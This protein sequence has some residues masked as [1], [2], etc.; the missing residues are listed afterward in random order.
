MEDAA[1]FREV[2]IVM[3]N[4]GCRFFEVNVSDLEYIDSSGL[5]VL[6]GINNRCVKAGGFL[7]AEGARGA[8]KDLFVLTRLDLVF[9]MAG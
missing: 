6:V 5:G 7:L 4:G 1:D 3:S 8:V 9:R 2:A